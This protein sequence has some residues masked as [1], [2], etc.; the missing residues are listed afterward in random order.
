MGLGVHA[1]GLA[2]T[3]VDPAAPAAPVTSSK[4]ADLA[5]KN[6]GLRTNQ[7]KNENG[8]FSTHM[9]PFDKPNAPPGTEFRPDS[10][11]I[12]PGA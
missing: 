6:H 3:S 4:H 1:A 10:R 12:G 5:V 9:A 2:T 11:E 8:R 7:V